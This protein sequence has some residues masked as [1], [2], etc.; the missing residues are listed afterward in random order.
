MA[1]WAHEAVGRRAVPVVL[2][3]FEEDAVARADGLDLPAL[4]PAAAHTLGDEDRLP[5]RVGVPG[6]A[7]ARGEVDEGGGERRGPGRRGDGVDVDVAAEPVR[8]ALHGL[9]AR[10]GDLHC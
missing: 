2:A 5:V 3:G 6:G 7:R 1:T 10:A 4:A 8:G 9:D